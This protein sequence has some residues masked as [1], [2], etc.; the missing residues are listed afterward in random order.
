MNCLNSTYKITCIEK[1]LP[2]WQLAPVFIHA[3]IFNALKNNLKRK[4]KD[5]KKKIYSWG[6]NGIKMYL[7]LFRFEYK[8]I[9]IKT[10][11]IK[12]YYVFLVSWFNVKPFKHL[13]RKYIF[14]IIIILFM[15]FKLN[16]SIIFNWLT[17]EYNHTDV[18][19]LYCFVFNKLH[20]INS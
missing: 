9:C 16:S 8:H 14:F 15:S 7:N 12:V 17:R 18:C 19:F 4:E 1:L 3:Y 10:H 11:V 5:K 20:G 13:V 6:E 2:L